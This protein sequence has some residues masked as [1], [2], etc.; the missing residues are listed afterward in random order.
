MRRTLS[1]KRR[2]LGVL[3]AKL[4]KRKAVLQTMARIAKH[5]FEDLTF[6]KRDAVSETDFDVLTTTVPAA[7]LLK[8]RIKQVPT[9][10]PGNY[11]PEACEGCT[12]V[13]RSHPDILGSQSASSN[14]QPFQWEPEDKVFIVSNPSRKRTCFG[15]LSISGV[16]VLDRYGRPFPTGKNRAED[17]TVELVSTFVVVVPPRTALRLARIEQTSFRFYALPLEQLPDPH[18]GWPSSN[19]ADSGYGAHVIGFPLPATAGPYL[20]T[21]GVGGHLTHFFPQSYHAIDLRC[22]CRTPILSAGPGVV[23]EV[24]E[25]HCCGGI[26]ASNLEHWNAVS[27]HLDSGLIVEYLHTLPGSSMVRVGERVHTGQALCLSG[28][29][30]FAPEPHLHIE[31]HRALDPDGPSVPICFSCSGEADSGEEPFLPTAG[32]WYNPWGVLSGSDP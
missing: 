1:L 22:A 30:G 20:C 12:I 18:D 31:V 32:C 19:F 25:R 3:R 16:E 17:G 26:H 14:S 21:Q 11:M 13:H 24:T 6:G 7:K 28:D 8:R 10:L 2:R 4:R 9:F 29:I 15:Y 23:R 5:S 27:V